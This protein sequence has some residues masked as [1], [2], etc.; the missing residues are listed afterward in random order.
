M[1]KTPWAWINPE[2]SFLRVVPS[3]LSIPLM[4]TP[5]SD[6]V[7]EMQK[8]TESVVSIVM[9][10]QRDRSEEN[11]AFY[12][13]LLQQSAITSK[14]HGFLILRSRTP[15]P[16][17]QLL[18]QK[19]DGLKEDVWKSVKAAQREVGE[20]T[21]IRFLLLWAGRGRSFSSANLNRSLHELFSDFLK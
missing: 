19:C 8:H 9:T 2:F 21:E 3:C 15:D 1:Q 20:E 18:N 13:L 10:E 7:V 6:Y 17:W 14:S 11:V 12:T 16:G 5:G 4:S